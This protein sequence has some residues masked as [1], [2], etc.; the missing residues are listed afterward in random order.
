MELGDAIRQA[1]TASGLSQTTLAQRA[2][3]S[4]D[5]VSAL[6]VHGAGTV[7]LLSAVAMAIDLRFTG[8]PRG[9]SFG[10]QVRI[11]RK[12]RMWSQEELAQ[13]AEVSA[14]AIVRL[15]RGNARVATLQA[16]LDVLAPKARPRKSEI[17]RWGKGTR[18]VRFTPPEIWERIVHVLGRVDLDP[19]GDLAS[20]VGARKTFTELDDGLTQRWFGRA[21]VNPPYSMAMKFTRK[22][23]ESFAAGHCSAVMLLLPNSVLHTQAFHEFGYG[24]ADVFILQDRIRF[25][26]ANVQYKAPFGNSVVLYGADDLMIKRTLEVFPC[27]HLQKAA[28]LGLGRPLHLR[29][30]R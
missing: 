19:C 24:K 18:D 6:E 20:P 27:V 3:V 10:D 25:L 1:R 2:G 4:L 12:R 29:L 13:R 30:S 23:Y 9:R 21:Y 14:P 5:A 8:L 17:A 15:E 26:S 22:A 11:L 16:A 7:R 28:S